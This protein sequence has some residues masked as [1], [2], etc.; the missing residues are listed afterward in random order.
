MRIF[1][2][3]KKNFFGSSYESK[4]MK[5][6]SK[7]TFL[8]DFNRETEELIK[9]NESLKNT[10]DE[11]EKKK[12]LNQIN[13]QRYVI[14]GLGKVY[15]ELTNSPIPFYGLHNIR[16]E[17][18]TSS[19]NVDFLLVTHQF[20]CIVKCKSL[21]GN[22]EIDSYGNFYR[23][24]RKNEKWYKEGIYSPIEQ[25]RR[26]ELVLKNVLNGIGVEKLHIL[27]FTVFTNPKATINFKESPKDII[28]KIIKLDL[29][30]TKLK[31]LVENTQAPTTDEWIAK[32]IAETLIKLD[33]SNIQKVN[34]E[35][36]MEKHAHKEENINIETT[37]VSSDIN[38]EKLIH[39]LKEYRKE[40]AANNNIPP[41]FV[42]N[43]VEMDRLLLAMPKN[44][45]ELLRVKG[46]GQVK[47][48]R[49]GDNI[50]DIL[51]SL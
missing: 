27:S 41:Y 7:P 33:K 49:Y 2:S 18:G 37:P 30:N 44:K 29:V 15:F 28:D 43:N 39:A 20:C 26:A 6:I 32:E 1:D 5:S 50:L 36:D 45:E 21:Q 46:F 10:T 3:I 22:I 11:E 17:D 42:F 9:L 25:N 19:A 24:M 23:W 4:L 12:L 34:T 35:E 48:D 31:E 51:N 14:D 13:L 40:T 8:K 38:K 47:V 16:L